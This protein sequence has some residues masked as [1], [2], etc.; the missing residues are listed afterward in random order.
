MFNGILKLN[1]IP[2]DWKKSII[3]PIHKGNKKPKSDPNSYRPVSLLCTIFKVF[4]KVVFERIQSFILCETHFP[5]VQQQGYQ[6]GLSCTTASFILQET[7][8]HNIEN[9]SN[10]YAAFLDSTKAFDSVWRKGLMVKLYRLGIKDIIWSIIDDCH[11]DTQ[12]SVVVNGCMS[13]WFCVEQGVR[14][15]GVL[16]GFLYSVFI[17]DLLT[18]LTSASKNTGILSL[19]LSNPTLADDLALISL[20]PLDLQML[21]NVAYE[22]SCKWRFMFSAEKSSVVIFRDNRKVFSN[23][24]WHVGKEIIPISTTYLHLGVLQTANLQSLPNTYRLCEKGRKSYFG[25]KANMFKESHPKTSVSIYKKVILP[26]T[27]FGCEL[28]NNLKTKDWAALNRFQHLIVKDIQNFNK[29]TK[30]AICESMLGLRPIQSEIEKRKLYFLEKL[31][32]MDTN[33]LPKQVF[34]TRL[35][36]YFNNNQETSFGFVKDICH[37]LQKHSLEN[38]IVTYIRNACFPTKNI[39]KNIVKQT[40][41]SHYNSTWKEQIN[42]NPEY[43]DFKLLQSAIHL[44]P[45]WTHSLSSTEMKLVKYIASIWT[46]MPKQDTE[47]CIICSKSF[48]NVFQHAIAS[49]VATSFDRCTFLSDLFTEYYDVY[50][51]FIAISEYEFYISVIKGTHD[52]VIDHKTFMLKCYSFVISSITTYHESVTYR[53]IT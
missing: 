39:W 3:V 33:L 48:T 40:I 8:Y 26:S 16:S 9:K 36:E 52:H 20:S 43:E 7:I 24:A 50:E 28:W 41:H 47:Q 42:S 19:S 34:A 13:K 44:A 6:K 25:I 29:S 14:Q 37:I 12:S 32:N 38:F 23:Y 45:L 30:S 51:E 1:Y 17:N 31:C 49:C 35:F 10:V 22:Y 4:E 21:L 18:Q 53:Q 15:G 27:L 11:I 2:S 5:D 46:L